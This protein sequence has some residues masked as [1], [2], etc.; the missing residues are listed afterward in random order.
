MKTA[1]GLAAFLALFSHN[2][3]SQ[4][5][6]Y[7]QR[8]MHIFCA[9]HLTVIGEQLDE[10]SD[11]YDAL[12]FFSDMHRDAARKL[13]ATPKHFNDV[14]LYLKKVRSSDEQKWNR[15]SSRSTKVCFSGS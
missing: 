11:E 8:N 4:E 5:I 12:K 9:S 6:D 13:G 1:V 10:Q 7:D 2:S 15:L 14:A 3:W